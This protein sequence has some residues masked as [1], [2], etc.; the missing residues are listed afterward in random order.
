MAKVKVYKVNVYNVM[1]DELVLSRRMATHEGAKKMGGFVL[2][3][4]EVEIDDSQLERGQKWT[5]RDF[6][7]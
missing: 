7:P 2:E 6:K 1:T 3:D 5:P 4:T